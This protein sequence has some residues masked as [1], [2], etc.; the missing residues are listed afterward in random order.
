MATQPTLGGVGLPYPSSYSE[1]VSYRGGSSEM[2]DGTVAFDLV[3]TS[4]KREF[5]LG[6]KGLTDAQRGAVLGGYAA[7]QSASATFLSPAN[8]SYTVT[9]H[10]EQGELEFEAVKQNSTTLRWSVTMRLREA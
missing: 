10:P 3:S 7:V 5:T 2:A 6:W 4:Q 1:R 8:T 9:R